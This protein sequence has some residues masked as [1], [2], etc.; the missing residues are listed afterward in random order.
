MNRVTRLDAILAG[1]PG[2]PLA[3]TGPEKCL[4]VAGTYLT[5]TLWYFAAWW[6]V[7][8]HPDAAPYVDQAFLPTALQVQTATIA[9]WV[10][11]IVIALVARARAA[12]PRWLVALTIASAVWELVYGSYFFGFHTSLFGGLTIVAS[13]AVGWVLFER[14]AIN[15]AA[16]VL[17]V[18]LVGLAVL[19]QLHRIPYSPLF[20]EA[21]FREGVLDGSWIITM[22]GVTIVMMVFIL[23]IVFFIIARWHDREDKL[24]VISQQL[25]RANDVISRYVASQLAEQIRAGHFEELER[26]ERRRLTLFFSDIEDFADTADHIEPE[27]LADALNHYLSEMARIGQ[28]HG[29]TIDKFAGDAV[30]IFFGAPMPM[31]D[32][33]Q[34][35]HAVSMAMEMQQAM[36]T[37]R[38]AWE[39]AGFERP[40]HIRIGINTGHASIGNFGSPERA[41]Y[42]AIG[43]HVN[44]AARL[45]AQCAPDRIL[46]SHATWALVHDEI[47]CEAKGEIT[48]K[49]IRDPVTVYEVVGPRGCGSLPRHDRCEA[50]A[51]LETPPR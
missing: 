11:I 29:G 23:G 4:F 17:A 21:P 30:M 45:Q 8:V 50:V 42:T 6:Y 32:H 34:A 51:P 33:E 20:R 28:R 9:A 38:T 41:D 35:L 22:G 24:A 49:G 31:A 14:R 48:V 47:E 27:D 37:M 5:F 3:W 15:A 18:I 13:G 12:E 16:A 43:R 44:L 10:T 40:F 1:R 7:L 39:A 26:H 2:D 19:E 36:V 25:S 46:I